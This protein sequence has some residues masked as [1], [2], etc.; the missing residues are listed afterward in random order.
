MRLYQT[1]GPA[2]SLYE[3]DQAAGGTGRVI[4]ASDPHLL[5]LSYD[6]PSRS[7]R[8]SLSRDDVTSGDYRVQDVSLY[9]GHTL[10]QR[11]TASE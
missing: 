10:L 9:E 1:I 7:V 6:Y 5:L 8:V 11:Q 4:Q 2:M 3:L